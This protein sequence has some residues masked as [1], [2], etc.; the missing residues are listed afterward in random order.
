MNTRLHNKLRSG[1]SRQH[2]QQFDY[3]TSGTD[4][5]LPEAMLPIPTTPEDLKPP[6]IAPEPTLQPAAQDLVSEFSYQDSLPQ[7]FLILCPR[8]AI[9]HLRQST[10]AISGWD[11]CPLVN[12]AIIH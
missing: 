8:T 2:Y 4:D 6:Q 10:S 9:V 3:S 1:G 5:E 12:E 11:F 7:F